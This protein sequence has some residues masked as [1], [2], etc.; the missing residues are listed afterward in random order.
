VNGLISTASDVIAATTDGV[1]A[2][3]DLKKWRKLTDV[4]D[5]VCLLKM[6]E[7]LIVGTA[8]GGAWHAGSV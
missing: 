4:E 8:G 3:S 7:Q 5:G 6:G 2:S 1:F